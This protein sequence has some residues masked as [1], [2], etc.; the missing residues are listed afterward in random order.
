MNAHA[1]RHWRELDLLRALAAACMVFN[2]FAVVAPLGAAGDD[3]VVAAW[4]FVGS[5][6]PVLFFAATGIGHGIQSLRG[7]RPATADVAA[8]VLALFAADAALWIAP[9][10]RVGMDFLGFIALSMVLLEL[11]RSTPRSGAVALGAAAAVLAARFAVGPLLRSQVDPGQDQY[12]WLG[13]LL[14]I[15]GRPG[16]SYP[17]CPWLSFPLA[18]YAL[19]RWL[20]SRREDWPRRGRAWAWAALAV[21]AALAACAALMAARGAVLFRWGT[22]SLAYVVAGY[23]AL[24]LGAGLAAILPGRTPPGSPHPSDRLALG[25]LRSLAIVPIHYVLIHAFVASI[26][27]YQG[28]VDYLV[29]ASAVT[30]LSFAASALIAPLSRAAARRPRVAGAALI[31]AAALGLWALAQGRL[32]GVAPRALV[33]LLLCLWLAMPRRARATPQRP[34]GPTTTADASP[35]RF[36]AAG[37]AGPAAAK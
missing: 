32:A 19:G 8:R 31:V 35:N 24:A 36:F 25:G 16:F 9:D 12:S 15:V 27:G 7:R 10:R 6:A 17:P 5:F 13:F 22:L 1:K 3:P 29:G 33:Q 18:G 11:L 4:S 28:P 21:G 34:D 14:G 30:A 37:P 20:E 23:A 2:H 26:G